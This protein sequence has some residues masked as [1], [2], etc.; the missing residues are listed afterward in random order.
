VPFHS[1]ALFVASSTSESLTLQLSFKCCVMLNYLCF[2]C[3]GLIWD[4]FP[5]INILLIEYAVF[6]I[7]YYLECQFE[8]YSDSVV[9]IAFN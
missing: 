9:M 3:I 2:I 8:V 5:Y 6:C 4:L 1:A 7:I